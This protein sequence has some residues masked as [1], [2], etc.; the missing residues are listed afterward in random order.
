MPSRIDTVKQICNGG[1]IAVVRAE[2]EDT[3][4]KIAEAC[5][6][7]GVTALE[8]TFTVPGAEKVINRLVKEY[9]KGDILIGA[10]T[11]LDEATARIAILNGAHFV[12]SPCCSLEVLKT[13]NRYDIA[14]TPGT[15]TVT[16]VITAIE[17]G[18]LM[19]KAFPGDILGP[20]FIKAV[21][22]PIPHAKM[23]PTGGVSLDNI[24]KWVA[25]G[26]AAIGVG[27]N[28]TAG[29]KTGDY[30]SI[31]EIAKQFLEKLQEARAK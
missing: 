12:V 5:R 23:V 18:A 31:T 24:D 22:G 7:G 17:H 3:A 30:K 19:V 10:G 16:E 28:L 14:C 25:A 27:G 1:L 11:V 6:L 8:I 26:A 4:L 29:A 21:R 13:C 20:N 15:M 2:N 9:P